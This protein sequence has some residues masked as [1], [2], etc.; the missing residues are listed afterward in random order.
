[1]QIE[2]DKIEIEERRRIKQHNIDPVLNI[3]D[4][5]FFGNWFECLFPPSPKV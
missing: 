4:K 3:Y 5:G 1:M 2:I